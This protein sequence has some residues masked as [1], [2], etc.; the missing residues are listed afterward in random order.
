MEER[1]TYVGLDVH[2]NM[3]NVALLR[4]GALTKR[5]VD[6]L[7]CTV[8]HSLGVGTSEGGLL[9]FSSPT[10]AVLEP[11]RFRLHPASSPGPS[12]PRVSIHHKDAAQQ[13]ERQG[14]LGNAHV[15]PAVQRVV[16][17]PRRLALGE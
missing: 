9:E 6:A 8:A 17:A 5:D 3:I 11:V 14:V 7:D 4:P 16:I 10:V 13:L 15:A 12:T 1:N 2:K